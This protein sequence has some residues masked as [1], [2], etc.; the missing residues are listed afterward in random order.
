MQHS[1]LSVLCTASKSSASL[2]RHHCWSQLTSS[3]MPK[4]AE[5]G[6]SKTI[7]APKNNS[8]LQDFIYIYICIHSFPVWGRFNLIRFYSTNSQTRLLELL[9]PPLRMII[10]NVRLWQLKHE[11]PQYQ[12]PITILIIVEKVENP[13]E[14]SM[15]AMITLSKANLPLQTRCSQNSQIGRFSSQLRYILQIHLIHSVETT[16]TMSH[17]Y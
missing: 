8:T 3:Q 4:R 13:I 10:S 12:W 1:K 14:N 15:L 11:V 16:L 9:L 2:S 5:L 7:H 6:F 17:L